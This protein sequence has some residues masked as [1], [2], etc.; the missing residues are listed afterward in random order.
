MKLNKKTKKASALI[1]TISAVAIVIFGMLSTTMVEP[2]VAEPQYPSDHLFVDET[3]LLKTNET[4]E[5]VD[6]TCNLFLT[7]I[8]EK[9][10][11]EIKVIAYVIEADNNFAVYEKTVEIGEI[12]A[13][14]TAKI[15]IPVV[16]SN[17]S[18]KIKI[19]LFE[20]GL[21]VI[22]GTLIITAS[23]IYTW[24]DVE[25]VGADGSRTI[26]NV[27]QL[28]GWNLYNSKSDFIQIRSSVGN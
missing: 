12:G 27:Q 7:N 6:I 9:E 26:I 21:L 23:P 14:S 17:N 2:I 16:L 20:D 24:R 15:E 8:W 4:N 10:S 3:I 11:G 1:V 19:L 18:Y 28:E 13:N 25:H 22:K 5:S